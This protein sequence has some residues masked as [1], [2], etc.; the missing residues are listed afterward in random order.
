MCVLACKLELIE[1]VPGQIH[2]LNFYL[3]CVCVDDV[4]RLRV[5]L[6]RVQISILAEG[7]KIEFFWHYQVEKAVW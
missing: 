6:E 1:V 5:V 2:T 4:V 7:L 3:F